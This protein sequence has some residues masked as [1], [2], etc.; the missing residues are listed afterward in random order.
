MNFAHCLKM[1][2]LI[3]AIYPKNLKKSSSEFVKIRKFIV[4]II[5]MI[6][7]QK[8]LFRLKNENFEIS[9]HSGQL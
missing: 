9:R 5:F 3:I 6:S 2:I 1:V 4:A 7:P 8:F